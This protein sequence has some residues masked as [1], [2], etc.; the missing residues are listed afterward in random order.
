MNSEE[1]KIESLPT[2]FRRSFPAD[3]DDATKDMQAVSAEEI[4][5]ALR[6]GM[7]VEIK[8]AVIRGPLTLRSM[9]IEPEISIEATRLT[10]RVDCSY[11]EFKKPLSFKT[12]VFE[13]DVIFAGSTI[14]KDILLEAAICK[15]KADFNEF[16]LIGNLKATGAVFEGEADLCS[17]RIGSAAEFINAMFKKNANFNGAQIEGAAFFDN[18]KFEGEA[19]FGSARVGSAAVFT[20]TTFKQN[21]IFNGTRMDRGAFFNPATF[22]DEADFT[23]ARIGMNANFKNAVFK[24]NA[25]FNG[26]QID[27]SAQFSHAKFEGGVDFGNARIGSSAEFINTMFKKDTNFTSAQI[28]GSA[29]FSPAKFEGD[30]IFGG[31]R[32]GRSAVFTNAIFEQRAIFSSARIE[33]D[34]FFNFAMFKGDVSFSSMYAEQNILLDGASFEKYVS[35]Q[36]S[37]FGTI[38]FGP[39]EDS[40]MTCSFSEKIDWRGCTYDRIHPT[41]FWMGLMDRLYPYDRQPYTQLEEVFRKSGD[42]EEATDV[43]YHR[44][45]F[46]S[47]ALKL[48]QRKP[49][50]FPVFRWLA[51]RFLWLVTGYGVRLRRIL[52]PTLII[53]LIGMFIFHLKGAVE[54]KQETQT[55]VVSAPVRTDEI[56]PKIG[57]LDGFWISLRHFL[58]VEIPAGSRWKPTTNSLCTIQTRWGKV[59]MSFE[60]FATFLKLAGWILV[61]VGVAGLTGILKR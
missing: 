8:N 49:L 59:C 16:R 22:E 54:P 9:V 26:S 36:N 10:H 40:S 56:V 34:T 38:F 53:L 33:K 25:N 14:G 32:I 4:L 7:Q 28:D 51:D 12:S 5:G 43:Y 2:I 52:V 48:F 27:G 17:A 6:S 1:R 24:K 44:K 21:A 50:K 18:A 46:E 39:P 29:H 37:H 19:D 47:K 45:R 58:P 30:A 15:E 61:P 20:N 11:A 57:F 23:V 55:I 35:L 3:C 13:K 60:A 41:A 42:D 31:T